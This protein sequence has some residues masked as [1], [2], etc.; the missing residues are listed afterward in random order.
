MPWKWFREIVGL[1]NYRIAFV[2]EGQVQWSFCITSIQLSCQSEAAYFALFHNYGEKSERVLQVIIGPTSTL[3][4]AFPTP[5]VI[6]AN[7]AWELVGRRLNNPGDLFHATLV[8]FWARNT[9]N[10]QQHLWVGADRE[11][12]APDVE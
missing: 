8:G 6:E 3:S 2:N 5:L 7:Q 4:M 10:L 1:T 9:P 12:Q 11:L